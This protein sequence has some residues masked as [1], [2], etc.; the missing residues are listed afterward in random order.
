MPAA[1]PALCRPYREERSVSRDLNDFRPV[2]PG[3][4]NMTDPMEIQ[5]WCA[6]LHCTE[7]ELDDAVM[8]VGE[9]ISAVRDHLETLAAKARE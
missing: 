1:V 7:A 8:Q 3:R 5:Y 6:E 9:N 4:I 2:D